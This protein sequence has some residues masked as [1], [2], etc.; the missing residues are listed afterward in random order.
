MKVV[1]FSLLF[2]IVGLTAFAQDGKITGTLV[3]SENGE[4]LIGANVLIDGT[5]LGA[6]TD[7]DG[8]YSI[9]Q[10]PAGTY[11][12]IFSFISYTKTTVSNVEMKPGETVKLDVALK[13]EAIET[14]EVVVTAKLLENTEATLLLQRQKSTQV[15]DAI[16]SEDISR[17]GSGDAANAMTKVTGA[18]TVD[19]KYVYIRGLGERYSSTQLNGS[20]IPSSDPDK[21]TVQLDIFPA[22][23]IENIV[24]TKT[25][26]PDMPGNYTG[27]AVN[28]GT[29][30]FPEKLTV[31]FSASTSFNSQTT[32]ESGKFLF[33]NGG[34]SD[35]LGMDDGTRDI[36]SIITDPNTDIP[37]RSVVYANYDEA[38]KLDEI[39][40]SFSPQMDVSYGDARINQ[41]YSFSFGN[42]YTLGE[43][44]L[45]VLATFSY[46]RKNSGYNDGIVSRYK[47]TG[48]VGST[49]NLTN[50]FNYVDA[51]GVDEVNWGGLVNVAYKFHPNHS[52]KANYMFNQSG[53]SGARYLTGTFPDQL[54]E[55]RT[56]ETRT[57]R[58][59][60]RQLNTMQFKGEHSFES[61]GGMK[62]DWLVSFASN[63]Q[64]E[65]DLRYFSNHYGTL[66]G[67]TIYSIS[68]ANYP[69]PTRYFRKLT[70]DNQNYA[71]NL[72]IPFKQ[73]AD[74]NSKFK[75]GGAFLTKERDFSTRS[76]K[77]AEV[78]S[79]Y[80]GTGNDY[81]AQNMGII[82]TRNDTLS[83]FGLALQ[84]A[85]EDRNN[86]SGTEDV[87][88]FYG[89][90]DLPLF[91]DFRVI[92]GARFE[93]TQTDVVS[94]DTTFEA[95]KLDE[96]DI[97][98]S[99]SFLYNLSEKMNLRLA[100]GRTLARPNMR[101][102]APFPSNSFVSGFTL[103]GNPELQRTLID[104]FD[105]RWEWFIR[106]GEIVAV[107]G[108]YKNFENPIERVFIIGENNEISYK[109]VDK[110]LVYG[111][112]FEFRK[113]LD[114]L[115]DLLDTDLFSNFYIGTN[116]TWVVSQVNIGE[117]ELQSIRA[118]DPDAPDTR[119]L[120]G[121]SPY[122]INANIAY[123][124]Y[125]IGT[126]ISLFYNVFGER[127]SEVSQ[128]ATPDVFEQA[129]NQLDFIA[130][131]K[132]WNGF[133]LKFSI[134]NILDEPIKKTID[135]KDTEYI[136][137]EYYRGVDYSI[138]FSWNLE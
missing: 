99:L 21:R 129:R 24:T 82:E 117:A 11:N 88:A 69:E 12:V 87:T 94:Q 68:P 132:I 18:S 47:L 122:I 8:H 74:L 101:E 49:D 29:K 43:Q 110:A 9:T 19:G 44:P 65:P 16:S 104:N 53:E 62:A 13:P 60:E 22:N 38:Q 26:T 72:E 27:G 133:S 92:T 95:G 113:R 15:S 77:L 23:L 128:S 17:S 63:T 41:S 111:A 33:Y 39:T 81:F 137:A 48:D 20:E 52:V 78:N 102:L 7:I 76:F 54:Q 93:T 2:F 58:Y 25:F 138:G 90:V 112:E 119:R 37:D 118:L 66:N 91:K 51:E 45:G 126:S 73:W 28:I 105:L 121:Q 70:E 32:F 42:Q 108:F 79:K 3:D 46:S 123:Q 98:P 130:S 10:V 115:S 61:I 30:S 114:E 106:P 136:I 55:D 1:L 83:I 100:Y 56:F 127:L 135:F 5:T 84:D 103:N 97:L 57:L 134:K 59:V 120:Q 75:F 6:A 4:P 64:D 109:N 35:W 96:S 40:R 34:G 86:Y 125:E 85:S 31:S 71:L 89:M 107:S 36:P 124:N 67:R 116:F 14:D 131:Q 80:D 50:L